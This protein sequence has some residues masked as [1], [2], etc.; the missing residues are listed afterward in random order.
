MDFKSEEKNIWGNDMYSVIRE[1]PY[2]M[3]HR[4]CDLLRNQKHQT[5]LGNNINTCRFFVCYKRHHPGCY[6]MAE[7]DQVSHLR[8]TLPRRD[9]FLAAHGRISCIF[10]RVIANKRHWSKQINDLIIAVALFHICN[11]AYFGNMF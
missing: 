6:G 9:Y 8:P 7:K 2:H 5:F 3:Y 1:I 10:P 11:S 4:C